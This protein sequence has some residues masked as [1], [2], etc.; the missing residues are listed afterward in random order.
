MFRVDDADCCGS[1]WT[2]IEVVVV[3]PSVVGFGASWC[4]GTG[5]TLVVTPLVWA[6]AAVHLPLLSTTNWVLITAA[7][8]V[9]VTPSNITC[10][11]K[12]WQFHQICRGF[13]LQDCTG[14]SQAIEFSSG[15]YSSLSYRRRIWI[16]PLGHKVDHFCGLPTA[17]MCHVE[18]C[19]AK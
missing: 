10:E 4:V 1:D 19:Q 9:A 6:V 2:I 18:H 7:G 15:K 8:E 14:R 12:N 17:S 11:T 5:V 3:A 13:Q 16:Q